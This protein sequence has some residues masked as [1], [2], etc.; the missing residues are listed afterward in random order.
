M[1]QKCFGESILSRT[2]VFEQYKAFSEG[3]EIVEN[4]PHSNRLSTSVNDDYIEKKKKIK[5]IVLKNHCVSFRE[6]AQALNNSTQ[7]IL[8]DVLDMS[9]ILRN[10]LANG[11]PKMN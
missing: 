9:Q 5:E 10:N 7:Q 1:F 6:I 11:T 8:V 2:E 3:C 4:L